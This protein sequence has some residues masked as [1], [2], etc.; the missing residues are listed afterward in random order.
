MK[1]ILRALMLVVLVFLIIYLVGPEPPRPRLDSDLPSVPPEASAL[2]AF[3]AGK[4]RSFRI[5]P[6]NEP[7]FYWADDSL[8]ER[9]DWA[10]LYLHGFSA[11]WYEGYPVNTGF[12]RKYR[13]NAYF[14]LLAAHGLET[15]DALVDMTPDALW[16]SAQEALMIARKIGR[17]VIIM[18]TST[19]GTLALKLAA[20][21]PEYVDGLILY[22]PNVR[23]NN[24]AAFLLSKPWGL[25]IAR[26]VYKSSY[27]VTNEDFDSRQCQYWYCKY[28]IEA[29]VYL[30]QLVEKTM[31]EEVF[32]NVVC[33]VFLGY[34]YKDEANQDPVVR[35]DAALRM[36]DQLGTDSQLKVKVAFPEAGDHVIAG[37]LF[38][39]SVDEVKNATFEFAEQVLKL[40]PG[41]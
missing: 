37:E 41:P 17:K 40:N 2:E 38:S 16:E 31:R 6:D 28:R 10:L 27:R 11:S 34:Y 7:R 25:H 3:V 15:E 30:Q 9:T 29:V 22:S 8:K 26:M 14:P 21:Y 24:P 36:F 20:Q 1:K 39:K 23:I 12:A 19:G 13:C 4:E 5:R 33:P 35:V 18:S 32:R